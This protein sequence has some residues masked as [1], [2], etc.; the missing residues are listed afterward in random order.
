MTAPTNTFIT[1]NIIGEKESVMDIITNVSPTDAPF[2]TSIEDDSVSQTLHE[3]QTDVLA[4]AATNYALEGDNPDATAAVPTVR[5]SNTC[6]ISDYVARVSGTGRAVQLHGREDELDYQ[7]VKKTKELRRDMELA[8]LDN[9]AEVTTDSPRETGGIE[10]WLNTNT[11][12]G[13]GGTA[14][15]LGNTARTTGT[16]RQLTEALVKTQLA[17][18]YT[19]GGDPDLILVPASIKQRFSEFTGNATRMINADDSKL[20]ATIDKLAA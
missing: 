5:L 18:I 11:S 9:N 15:S 13:A 2:L 19:N 14:G 6:Q 3:W 12:V 20:N 10:A 16:D 7:V 17:S 8:L 1:D 4:A